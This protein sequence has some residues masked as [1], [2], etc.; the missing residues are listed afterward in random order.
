M[1]T[2][3]QLLMK[4]ALQPNIATGGS[5]NLPLRTGHTLT[6]TADPHLHAKRNALTALGR[7]LQGKQ[8]S[9]TRVE[10]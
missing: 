5:P 2:R 8:A 3:F 4:N 7:I 1:K 9:E 10:G 6:V